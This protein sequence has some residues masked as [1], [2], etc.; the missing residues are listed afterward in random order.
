MNCVA[1]RLLDAGP[2]PGGRRVSSGAMAT[3]CRIA[4]G[5]LLL[6]APRAQQAMRAELVDFADL[7]ARYAPDR[8][9]RPNEVRVTERFAQVLRVALQG[10]DVA[11]RAGAT[12]SAVNRQNR[13]IARGTPD[14]VALV[15][16]ALAALRQ[17][18]PPRARLQCSLLTLP[19][20]L[21]AMRGLQVGCAPSDEAAFGQLVRDA[22]KAKGT[23]QN[24]PEIVAEPL[25][26]FVVEP[27]KK[28]KEPPPDQLRLRGEMVPLGPREVLVAMQLVQGAL[29]E[30]PTQPVKGPLLQRGLR[31]EAGKAVMMVV[32]AGEQMHVGFVRCTEIAREPDKVPAGR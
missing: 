12:V 27:A 6:A 16:N 25:V 23:L 15:K 28:D 32:I 7:A 29:P 2:A 26:P 24:L 1:R 3:T 13:L 10:D 14:D 31:L 18:H 30:E 11:G 5:L 8:E 22:I 9:L 17:E 20:Q 21:G 4:A 19:W